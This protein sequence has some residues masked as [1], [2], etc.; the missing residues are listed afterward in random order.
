MPLWLRLLLRFDGGI[1]TDVQ[2]RLAAAGWVDALPPPPPRRAR[3]HAAGGRAAGPARLRPR[4]GA[5][6]STRLTACAPAVDAPLAAR[7]SDHLPLVAEFDGRP[8][9]LHSLRVD[10]ACIDRMH[11][12]A[13]GA[14][15]GK[16]ATMRDADRGAGPGRRHGRDRGLHAPHRL[17]GR[18]RDHPPAQARPD[19][20]AHDPGRH[21]RPDDRGRRG[22]QAGLQLARQ[23]GR[24]RAQ[25]DPPPDRARVGG[26][27]DRRS[28]SRS[29]AT[30][31]WSPGTPRAP[32]TCR[33]CR[34]ARTSRR[35]C[36]RPTR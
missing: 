33:S 23:P 1:R 2:D 7:A 5:R 28:R 8:P 36:R 14:M 13:R 34:C 20:R 22:P 15:P 31:G 27:G 18:P 25:R 30:S 29:T 35:T 4:P 17:L 6:C 9:P 11:R 3:V 12:S 10:A 24:R 16:V 26:G 21:L 32:R 19:A